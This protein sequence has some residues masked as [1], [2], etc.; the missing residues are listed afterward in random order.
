MKAT[1]DANKIYTKRIVTPVNVT[2]TGRI[3]RGVNQT[4]QL[5]CV[6]DDIDQ[7]HALRERVP[8]VDMVEADDAALALGTVERLPPLQRL[9]AAH[10]VFV[11]LGE[12]VNDDRNGQ[13]DYQ[14]AA[15]ATHGTNDFAKRSGGVDVPV[16]DRGH[17]DSRPPKRFGYRYKLGLR[18][19][20]FGEVREGREDENAHCEEQH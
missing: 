12:I 19:V 18:F 2:L 8:Q 13:R 14:H 16:S 6:Y 4:E 9:L 17:G 1:D 10:L 5:T 15:Y 20:F 11:E 3:Q 7:V